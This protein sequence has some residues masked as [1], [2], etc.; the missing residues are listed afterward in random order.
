M[1]LWRKFNGYHPYL[2]NSTFDFCKYMDKSSRKMS[3]EK[4]LMDY[5]NKN[6]N[7]NHSCPYEVSSY[8]EKIF[9]LI[10]MCL[11]QDSIIIKNLV[12]D[13]NYFKFLPWPPGNYKFQLMAATDNDWKTV[14]NVH[15]INTEINN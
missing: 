6:S 15:L 14:V 5:L 13:A 10:N 11:F 8:F 1:S 2:V 12:F 3:Y 4:V 7:L 9:L